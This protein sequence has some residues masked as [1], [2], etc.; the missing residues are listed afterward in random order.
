MASPIERNWFQRPR[1]VMLR[2]RSSASESCEA[3]ATSEFDEILI[4]LSRE[5][6][7][8]ILALGDSEDALI[9]KDAKSTLFQKIL[10][11]FKFETS[12]SSF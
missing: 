8:D 10:W 5:A 11:I 2:S 9:T 7:L 4:M 1:L 12:S 6:I 3:I